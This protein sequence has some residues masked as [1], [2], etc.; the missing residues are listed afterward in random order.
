MHRLSLHLLSLHSKKS[1]NIH[2]AITMSAQSG[3]MMAPINIHIPPALNSLALP[4]DSFLGKNPQYNRLRCSAFIFAPATCH[5]HHHAQ[6]SQAIIPPVCSCC[7]ARPPRLTSR[8]F[9]VS[10]FPCIYYPIAWISRALG[11]S[12]RA[13][14]LKACLVTYFLNSKKLY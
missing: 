1:Q 9:G 8:T 7:A 13:F 12:L 3:S 6:T 10:T 11:H 4:L 5:H 2:S 14:T